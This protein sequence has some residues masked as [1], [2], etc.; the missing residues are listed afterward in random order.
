MN[1]TKTFDNGYSI[2]VQ[3]GP[4]HYCTP[5]TVEVAV[6]DPNGNFTRDFFPAGHEDDVM[7]HVDAI[8]VLEI[9]GNVQNS[10]LGDVANF[11]NQI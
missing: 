4:R 8:T 2:S 10:I 5:G 9:I 6:F 3:S 1:F 7:G 11:V